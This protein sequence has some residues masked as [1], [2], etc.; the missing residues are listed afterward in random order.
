MTIVHLT[1]IHLFDSKKEGNMRLHLPVNIGRDADNDLVLASRQGY[2]SRRHARME[3]AHGQ[4]VLRDCHSTNGLFVNDRKVTEQAVT[5]GDVFAVG[6]YEVT[7]ELLTQCSNDACGEFVASDLQMCP[8][9]G[10]FLADA[11]TKETLFA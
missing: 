11:I 5:H 1:W 4:L 2:V 9:C 6:A 3:Y 8:W 10:R 7:I